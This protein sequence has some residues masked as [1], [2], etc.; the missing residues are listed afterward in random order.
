MAYTREYVRINHMPLGTQQRR[1]VDNISH[2]KMF[3]A[4][5]AIALMMQLNVSRV[6]NVHPTMEQLIHV[7]ECINTRVLNI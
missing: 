5:T 3:I 2:W 6:Q 1:F 7:N 4:S